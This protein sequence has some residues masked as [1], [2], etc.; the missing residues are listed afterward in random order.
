MDNSDK[1]LELLRLLPRRLG[2][3]AMGRPQKLE[4]IL[5]YYKLS[6]TDL[7]VIEKEIRSMPRFKEEE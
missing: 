4:K 5:M 7:D 6:D 3:C 2:L 1:I